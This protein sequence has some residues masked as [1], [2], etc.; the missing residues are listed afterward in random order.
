MT[1]IIQNLCKLSQNIFS[2]FIRTNSGSNSKSMAVL[3]EQ[4][5]LLLKKLFAQLTLNDI[6]FDLNE[7]SPTISSSP[8]SLSSLAP[9]TYTSIFQNEYFSLTIFGFRKPTSRIPLHD[10][11]GMHGFIKC[12]YGSIS[13]KSY[14]ILDN[15]PVPNEILNKI[16]ELSNPLCL[17]PS[18][19]VGEDIISI[20]DNYNQIGTLTPM[21]RNIHEIRPVTNQAIMADIISPPYTKFT[22]SYFYY[23]LDTIYDQHLDKNI[24]WLLR[25]LDSRDYYCDTLNYRGPNI[26]LV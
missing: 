18:I 8:T 24:T 6:N 5:I 3:D 1:T 4:N 17:V 22:N 11:P 21:D 10:H 20:N 26:I 19:Y 12:I 9:I 7:L 25:T 13:I 15:V 16:P 23:Y 2:T 14:T